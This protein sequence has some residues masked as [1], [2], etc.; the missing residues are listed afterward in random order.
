M[1]ILRYVKAIKAFDII[2]RFFVVVF[3]GGEE[4]KHSFRQKLIN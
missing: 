4:G 2:I 1:I 3:L